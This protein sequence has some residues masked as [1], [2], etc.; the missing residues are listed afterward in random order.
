MNYRVS[1]VALLLTLIDSVHLYAADAVSL[2]I[3]ALTDIYVK[4]LQLRDVGFIVNTDSFAPGEQPTTIFVDLLESR[5][6]C[7]SLTDPSYPA[8]LLTFSVFVLDDRIRGISA[9]GRLIN[10]PDQVLI[11]SAKK[12]TKLGAI[13]RYMN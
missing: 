9:S 5:A 12:K 6:C 8:R 2:A 1:I 11:Q 10:Q 13:H 4:P 7:I 3:T